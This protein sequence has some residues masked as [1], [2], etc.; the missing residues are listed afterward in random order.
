[1]PQSD[2][3]AAVAGTSETS[4]QPERA[5]LDEAVRLATD[6]VASGG[7][8]FGALVA[9]GGEVIAT[10]TNLVTVTPDPTAHGEVVAIRR[11]CERLGDFRLD[12]CVLVTSCEP[13]PL[14]LAA[15]LWARVDRV[16][17]GA[18]RHDAAAAGFDDR[19]FYELF[20]QPVSEWP[21][22]VTQVSIPERNAPFTA[23][24]QKSDRVEY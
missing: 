16:V 13:C 22:S 3:A 24:Q 18:D 8:P 7:G 2:S 12:G 6:S 9:R 5:W 21:T 15:S 11:A 23:W 4:Q 14:C 17:Y 10:G 19:E 1:M 20:G